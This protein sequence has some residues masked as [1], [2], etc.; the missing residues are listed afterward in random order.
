MP[1]NSYEDFDFKVALAEDGDVFSRAV[2][3]LW[4]LKKAL[5]NQAGSNKY[6]RWTYKL[7]K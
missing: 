1:Y 4:K 3:G 2:V 7:R 5:N 6:A